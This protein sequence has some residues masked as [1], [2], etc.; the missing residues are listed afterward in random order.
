MLLEKF[1]V[2]YHGMRAQNH[3]CSRT[4][5]S[6]RAP[7]KSRMMRPVAVAAGLYVITITPCAP[8]PPPPTAEVPPAPLPP[9]PPPPEP[10]LVE[11]AAPFHSMPAPPLPPCVWV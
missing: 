6:R 10:T 9:P 8:L 5:P 7:P 2:A 11:V 1:I 3:G 4:P